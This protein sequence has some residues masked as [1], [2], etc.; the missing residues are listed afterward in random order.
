MISGCFPIFGEYMRAE[1]L[2]VPRKPDDSFSVRQDLSNQVNN[3]WHYH[4]ELELVHILRGGGTQFVGD[5]IKRFETGDIVLVGANLPHFWR[6]DHPDPVADEP[7]ST[8][9]HFRNDLWG[10]AFLTLPETRPL[11]ALLERSGRG[12]LLRNRALGSRI[13]ELSRAEGLDRLLALLGVLRDI[14]ATPGTHLLSSIGFRPA[15]S[16]GESE[17]INAIYDFTLQHFADNIYLDE[18][19]RV[20][21]LVPNSFCRYFKAKTGKTYS[22]FVTEIRV[23]HACKLLLEG[24]EGIKQV[25]YDSG[26][27]NFTS[28]NAAFKKI[29]GKTPRAY[30]ETF[31]ER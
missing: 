10:N 29:T 7:Y 19:S 27:N 3:R 16:E 30:Q 11:K 13:G 31:M 8:V 15:F 26:F 14:A 6:Y 18:V 1:L 4:P 28:F 2:K 20:A 12:I 25:C 23:G 22:Q 9:I 17:R 24:K 5:N 21:Q